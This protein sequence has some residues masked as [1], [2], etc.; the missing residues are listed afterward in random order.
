M[1]VLG[2]S[3]ANR[4]LFNPVSVRFMDLV[5]RGL[6]VPMEDHAD[7]VT[8]LALGQVFGDVQ[9]LGGQDLE[10]LFGGRLLPPA[11]ASMDQ[12]HG[13]GAMGLNELFGM[14]DGFFERLPFFAGFLPGFLDVCPLKGHFPAVHDGGRDGQVFAIRQVEPVHAGARLR[15]GIVTG[16]V[17]FRRCLQIEQID[18]TTAV[19]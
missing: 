14:V 13:I 7:E 18:F 1:G 19:A 2:T 4:Y 10:L 16:P 9:S 12:A 3:R 17:Q 11:A 8:G 5:T 15:P 6:T